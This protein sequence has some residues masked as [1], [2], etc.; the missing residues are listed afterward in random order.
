MGVV[1][2]KGS[3][4]VAL[5]LPLHYMYVATMPLCLGVLPGF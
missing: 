3:L 2:A 1:H 4:E 5:P